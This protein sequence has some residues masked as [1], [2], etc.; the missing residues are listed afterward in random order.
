[1]RTERLQREYGVQLRWST[2]PL[3]PETPLE[4][5]ELA[6]LFAGRRA[7]IRDMLAPPRLLQVAA[8]E[9][10]PLTEQNR[11]YNRP[12]CQELGKKGREERHTTMSSTR[13]STQGL[14]P[15]DG[16][17]T[18]R[19]LTSWYGS[20]QQLD[21]SDQRQPD[22]TVLDAR[23]YAAQWMPAGSELWNCT[24]RGADALCKAGS[25]GFAAMMILC[26]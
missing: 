20:P 6:E 25:S 5:R 26:D 10:V 3:H 9:G 19:W 17:S 7:M 15:V 14:F 12:A 2:F 22:G 13:P 24:L 16:G 1:M 11:T 18:S 23:S 4:G 8:I 21:C